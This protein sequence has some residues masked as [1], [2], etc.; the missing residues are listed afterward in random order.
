MA[1]FA[2]DEVEG[3]CLDCIMSR[4]TAKVEG[5]GKCDFHSFLF[6]KGLM[7]CIVPLVYIWLL[8]L[9]YLEFTEAEIH[10][11]DHLTS[12]TFNLLAF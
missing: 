6:S 2:Y 11:V 8:L 4:N 1:C 7:H 9:L 5:P 10:N 3:S 12:I